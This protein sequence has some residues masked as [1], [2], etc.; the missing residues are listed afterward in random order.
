[1]LKTVEKGVTLRVKIT[2]NSCSTIAV[3][4]MKKWGILREKTVTKSKQE[5]FVTY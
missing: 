3:S 1:V 2:L 4:L 5:N